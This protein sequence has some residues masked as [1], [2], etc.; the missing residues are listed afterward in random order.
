VFS[1]PRRNPNDYRWVA[2]ALT[3]ATIGLFVYWVIGVAHARC[4]TSYDLNNYGSQHC[5]GEPIIYWAFTLAGRVLL[6]LFWPRRQ[7][8]SPSP[9]HAVPEYDE[10]ELLESDDELDPDEEDFLIAR[11][12]AVDKERKRQADLAWAKRVL[13]D[14]VSAKQ[15]MPRRD[16]IPRGVRHAVWVRDGGKCVECGSAEKLEFDH[17]IPVSMGGANTERNLQLLC[18]GCNRRKG[19][20]LG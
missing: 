12:K 19:K 3:L 9:L 7:V 11:A 6:A 2:H 17:I 15:S 14:G 1:R 18:E 8:E 5:V 16:A 4:T 10:A 20:S 13:T